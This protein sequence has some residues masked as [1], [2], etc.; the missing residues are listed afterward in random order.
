MR[1][2]ESEN[3]ILYF[4]HRPLLLTCT[5]LG[6]WHIW[7]FA[8]PIIFSWDGHCSKCRFCDVINGGKRKRDC[9]ED[10]KFCCIFLLSTTT[11]SSSSSSSLSSSEAEG[12]LDMQG[13]I[14][15]WNLCIAKDCEFVLHTYISKILKSH[16]TAV[17]TDI[18]IHTIFRENS[19]SILFFMIVRVLLLSFAPLVCTLQI[20]LKK[21]F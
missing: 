5:Y 18:I 9:V 2:F 8:C 11:A 6:I 12:N 17:H 4:L 10:G 14:L 21:N 20:Y 3:V 13:K 16:N 19:I 15:I 7:M 1:G